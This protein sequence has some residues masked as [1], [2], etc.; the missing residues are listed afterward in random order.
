MVVIWTMWCCH[1]EQGPE[2][3]ALRKGN[4]KY[5]ETAC[6]IAG[7]RISIINE[8]GCILAVT[9]KILSRKPGMKEGKTGYRRPVIPPNHLNESKTWKR[10][11]SR[12]G[13]GAE[14]PDTV[15][16]RR[17][18]WSLAL[19]SRLGSG[20]ATSCSV[21]CRCSSDP[22]LPWLWC[23]PVAAAPIQPSNPGT[24][25][26]HRCDPKKKK[27]KRQNKPC[28]AILLTSEH[29]HSSLRGQ[30]HKSYWE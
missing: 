12:Y 18:A 25:I 20:T 15:S 22:V 4:L 29:C 26:C 6:Q 7:Q 11:S 27:K 17:Q 5:A 2:I 14:E 21:G 1:R 13:S 23:R 16:L 9:E 3:E 24:S 10:R 30:K 28:E 19:L 8:W